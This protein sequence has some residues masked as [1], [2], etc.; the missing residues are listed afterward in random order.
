[1]STTWKIRHEGSPTSLDNLTLA[2][3]LEGLADGLWEPTD[4]V[5]G[6]GESAWVAIENHPQLAEAAAEI[7]PPPPRIYDDETRLDM[8]A[9]IDVCLVLLI[10]FILT[11]SYATLQAYFELPGVTRDDKGTLTVTDKV[12]DEEMIHVIVKKEGKDTVFRVEG[13][14]VEPGKLEAELKR[15][16]RSKKKTT[17]LLEHDDQVLQRDVVRVQDA[18]QGAGMERV[19]LAKPGKE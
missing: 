8:T 16:V 12:V 18:A 5:L 10:F 13:Q 17:L 14:V 19:L 6:P 1:M 11:T 15:F 9:L 7:E 2:Q 3:V 4:E